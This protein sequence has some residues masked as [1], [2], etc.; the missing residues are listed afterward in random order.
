MGRK[1]FLFPL[2]LFLLKFLGLIFGKRKVIDR[3]IESLRIDNTYTKEILN[4]TPKLT[5]EDGIR[6]MIQEK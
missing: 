5:T 4:W 3:L 6:R 1:T 2:P